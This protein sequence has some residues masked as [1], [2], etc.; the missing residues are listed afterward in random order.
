MESQQSFSSLIFVFVSPFQDIFYLPTP[1]SRKLK[2]VAENLVVSL[3]LLDRTVGRQIIGVCSKAKKA[4]RGY[5]PTEFGC[6]PNEMV[7]E[8]DTAYYHLVLP[9]DS[10]RL[11]GYQ[12]NGPY[13]G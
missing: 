11:P 12:I 13:T 1:P 2:D 7:A 6:N 3:D 8:G 5:M 9:H 4:D 10:L